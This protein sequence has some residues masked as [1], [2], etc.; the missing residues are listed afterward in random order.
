MD[1]SHEDDA[2]SFDP[3]YEGGH[4]A[5]AL[6]LSAR[7]KAP[8]QGFTFGRNQMRC[9]VHFVY[10]PKRRLSNIHFRIFFNQYGVLM[11]EDQSTNGTVVDDVCLKTRPGRNVA[12]TRT[13][14]SGSKIKILMAEAD[15]DLTFLVRIPRR[16][17][18]YE[19]AYRRNRM[20][21]MRR[22]EHLASDQE[23]TISAGPTGHVCWIVALVRTDDVMLTSLPR[24]IC[25]RRGRDGEEH[26]P[27][28]RPRPSWMRRRGKTPS[29]FPESGKAQRSTTASARSAKARSPPSTR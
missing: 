3:T 11:V 25:S 20:A 18:L 24:S 10:D 28:A 8:L 4:H 17:G 1:Y 12:T 9:D 16:D 26:R 5:I 15:R 7:T 6:R 29:I 21:H 23:Q 22:L 27:R 13:L 19:E 14:N 2:D